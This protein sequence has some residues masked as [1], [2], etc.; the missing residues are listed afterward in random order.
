MLK[1]SGVILDARLTDK[2]KTKEI[3]SKNKQLSLSQPLP[4]I[5]YKLGYNHRESL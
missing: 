2:K 3:E 5:V 4:P 1:S